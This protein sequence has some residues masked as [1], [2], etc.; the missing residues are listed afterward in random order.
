MTRGTGSRHRAGFT[1]LEVLV[2]F[3]ILVTALTLIAAEFSRHLA[4]LQRLQG[5]IT[6]HHSAERSLLQE[7][8]RRELKAPLSLDALPEGYTASLQINP[9]QFEQGPLQGVT[10]EQATAEISWRFR[11]RAESTGVGTGLLPEGS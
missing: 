1:L 10:L 5:S 7:I 9:I 2:A 8:L 6:A 4:V 3:G 11:G